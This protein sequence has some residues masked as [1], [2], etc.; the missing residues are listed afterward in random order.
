MVAEVALDP[1]GDAAP[2][3][4]RLGGLCEKGLEVTLHQRIERR[5]GGTLPAVDW[6]TFC[7]GGP[8]GPP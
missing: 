4:V 6:P 2:H 3:G 8:K 1:R 7:C 5:Q